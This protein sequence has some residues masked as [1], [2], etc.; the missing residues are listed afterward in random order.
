MFHLAF[1]LLC[2]V[3]LGVS[4]AAASANDFLTGNL[5]VNIDL[6]HVPRY[7]NSSA[8]LIPCLTEAGLNPITPSNPSYQNDTLPINL[9]LIYQPVALVYPNTTEDVSKAVRCGA[10]NDVKVTA[11]SGG[12]SCKSVFGLCNEL[13]H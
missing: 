11:R 9:R 5:K 10:A 3:S 1:K 12:H 4:W 13:Q 8:S 7:Y 2:F 6:E